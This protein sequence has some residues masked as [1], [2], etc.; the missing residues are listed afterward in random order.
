MN[1]IHLFVRNVYRVKEKGDSFKICDPKSIQS[2][3]MIHLGANKF[4]SLY[5]LLFSIDEH[6]HEFNQTRTLIH[7]T[8]CLDGKEK[9][10]TSPPFPHYRIKHCLLTFYLYKS[11]LPHSD[12]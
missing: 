9:K 10:P 7:C 4:Y 6:E 12:E 5:N 3:Q 11:R 1:W 8:Q 2:K